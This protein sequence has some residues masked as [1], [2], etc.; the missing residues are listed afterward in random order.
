MGLL[1]VDS[2]LVLNRRYPPMAIAPYCKTQRKAIS[3]RSSM[4]IHIASRYPYPRQIGLASYLRLHF[5]V[6]STDVLP[7]PTAS[8]KVRSKCSAGKLKQP[9]MQNSVH[10]TLFQYHHE[11]KTHETAKQR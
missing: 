4:N 6:V 7:P 5:D 10:S 1:F 9:L 11:P 8:Y 3:I 2:Q